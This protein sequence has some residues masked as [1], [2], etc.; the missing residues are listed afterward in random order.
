MGATESACLDSEFA[1]KSRLIMQKINVFNN[2]KSALMWRCRSNVYRMF[3]NLTAIRR[4]HIGSTRKSSLGFLFSLLPDR[5][6]FKEEAFPDFV[7]F[8][9]LRSIGTR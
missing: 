6:L 7:G 5:Q 4:K 3:P 1:F 9:H 8:V 2:G